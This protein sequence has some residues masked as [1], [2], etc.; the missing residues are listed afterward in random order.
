MH[1]RTNRVI[2]VYYDLPSWPGAVEPREALGL[3]RGGDM[4]CRR[5]RDGRSGQVAGVRRAEILK[6]GFW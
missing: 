3:A 1:D 5:G 4:E 2:G 6:G